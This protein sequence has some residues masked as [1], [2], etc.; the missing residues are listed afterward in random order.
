MRHDFARPHVFF[1]SASRILQCHFPASSAPWSH[2]SRTA[3]DGVFHFRP[4]GTIAGTFLISVADSRRRQ[5]R[6]D[7]DGFIEK[8]MAQYSF[9]P[10]RIL[11]RAS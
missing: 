6:D 11:P 2:D 1:F 10:S 7:L 4:D 8:H 5:P 3:G 9:E